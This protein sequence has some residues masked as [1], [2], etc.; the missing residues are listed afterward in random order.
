MPNRFNQ[1]IEPN[2]YVSQYVPL[3]LDFINQQGAMKQAAMDKT[4]AE[5]AAETDP[6]AKYNVNA[7]VKTYGA[8][9]IQDQDLGFAERQKQLIADID[10]KRNALADRLVS[11]KIDPNDPEI[12]KLHR[13]SAAA[14]AELAQYQDI[15]KTV[16]AENAEFSKNDKVAQKPWLAHQRLAYNTEYAND[17]NKG[18]RPYNPY[19]VSKDVNR[20]TD[21]SAFAQGVGEEVAKGKYGNDLDYI[22]TTAR[23]GY[24]YKYGEFGR[25][26]PKISAGFEAWY[27]N[28]D[29][30]NDVKSEAQ[31]TAILNGY[32]LNDEIDSKDADGNP[33]K[34]NVVDYLEDQKKSEL[35]TEALTHTTRKIDQ[36]LSEDWKFKMS[37]QDKL[38]HPVVNLTKEVE[39]PKYGTETND[40]SSLGKGIVS[41]K[42]AI[43]QEL[44]LIAA[45]TPGLIPDGVRPEYYLK[46]LD[47]SYP[48]GSMAWL[49]SKVDKL[50]T[51]RQDV[52]KGLI[53]NAED[54]AQRDKDAT[55][56]AQSKVGKNHL[57]EE[58]KL[59]AV[60]LKLGINYQE[61]IDALSTP[62]VTFSGSPGSIAYSTAANWIGKDPN[63]Q[64]F[65]EELGKVNASIADINK[66]K[67]E[68]LTQTS[69]KVLPL[70][71]ATTM[72]IPITKDQNT[73]TYIQDREFGEK[74]TRDVHAVLA[75]GGVDNVQTN[76]IG[77][78]GARMTLGEVIAANTLEGGAAPKPGIAFYT[79]LPNAEN[80]AREIQFSVGDKDV[81]IDAS[82]V[83]V[84]SRDGSQKVP[85]SKLQDTPEQKLNERIYRAYSNG[86]YNIDMGGRKVKLPPPGQLTANDVA[87]GT[88]ANNSNIEVMLTPEETA[89]I[90]GHPKSL[91]GPKA[92][93]FL[94]NNNLIK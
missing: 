20:S 52:V 6:L 15:A 45:K 18:S 27:Q 74:I 14:A 26:A 36:G 90:V 40:V 59:K 43:N 29:S 69:S 62:S 33:I 82:K 81:R 54:L 63:R 53:S 65:N 83:S 5:L 44:K 32:K 37:A 75:G 25:F 55:E 64:K 21:V 38:D 91:L 12:N 8:N 39:A 13:E 11:G 7:S 24:I 89:R 73:G 71:Q 28:S 35:L 66:V 4:K 46:A 30:K 84:D 92:V 79:Q 17:P 16:N 31:Q 56:Y 86:V 87:N 67:D 76:I 10:Q 85:L 94:V 60:A 41:N 88:F 1:L 23:P 48:G 78:N 42:E 49:K 68:Y 50:P 70:Q 77:E 3:P 72:F 61:A 22:S 9:G 19:G 57:E 93:D 2:K 58:N 34:V 47:D 80:G 51:D